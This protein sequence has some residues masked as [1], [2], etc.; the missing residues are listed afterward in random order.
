[1]KND[2]IVSV[3]KEVAYEIEAVRITATLKREPDGWTTIEVR[4]ATLMSDSP[5]G[6]DVSIKEGAL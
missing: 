2:E 6:W 1:M 5:D 4:H 3:L